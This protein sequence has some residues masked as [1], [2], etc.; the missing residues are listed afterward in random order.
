MYKHEF[1]N[2][3]CHV[4]FF[5]FQGVLG[6]FYKLYIKIKVRWNTDDLPLANKF[7]KISYRRAI[8]LELFVGTIYWQIFLQS[9]HLSKFI[10]DRKFASAAEI[11]RTNFSF[12]K[13]VEKKY[14]LPFILLW[15]AYIYIYLCIIIV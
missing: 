3:Y 5:A 7:N 10:N 8:V 1:M 13:T 15:H 11:I 12:K 9:V 14:F 2:I 6:P 4:D